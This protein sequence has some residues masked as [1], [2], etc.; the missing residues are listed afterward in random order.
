[1]KRVG[2]LLTAILIISS[3]SGVQHAVREEFHKANISRGKL[4]N[5]E[6]QACAAAL[7]QAGH[8]DVMQVTGG[9]AEYRGRGD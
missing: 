2:A 7:R 6:M 8:R 4:E 1:M 9:V 5:Q 3:C